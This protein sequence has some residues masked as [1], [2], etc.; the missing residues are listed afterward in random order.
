MKSAP[1][2]AVGAKEAADELT[3][4]HRTRCE[5]AEE[6]DATVCPPLERAKVTAVD[7]AKIAADVNTLVTNQNGDLKKLSTC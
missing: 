1:T 5:E 7:V 2:A 3:G 4:I 6:P